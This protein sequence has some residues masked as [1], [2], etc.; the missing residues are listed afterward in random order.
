MP[1]DWTS[2][3]REELAQRRE[4]GVELPFGEEAAGNVRSE[5]DWERFVSALERAPLRDGFPFQEPSGLDEI[6]AFRRSALHR[7]DLSKLWPEYD[8]RVLG[9]WLGRCA[10]CLLG[11]PV[12]GW[13]HERIRAYLDRAGLERLEGYLPPLESA[14]PE[15][16]LSEAAKGWLLGRTRWM[17]R[18]DDIDYTIIGLYILERY[19]TGF[20]SDDVADSWLSLLPYY[21]V[22][23]AERAAYR[24]LVAGLRPPCSAGYRNP[25][26]EWIGAQIRADIWGYVAPGDP[27]F[28]AELAWRDARVSHVKNGI[29]GAMFVAATIAAAFCCDDPLEAVLVGLG[30]IP[31]QSR[32][33]EAIRRCLRLHRE[34]KSWEEAFSEVRRVYGHYSW[35][36][37]IN[38]TCLVVLALLYGEGDFGK[39]VGLAVYGGWDTDCNG[40]TSGSILG[41]MLGSEGI[42][43]SWVDPLGDRV[44]SCVAGF[45]GAL[46]SDL[47]RRTAQAGRIGAR[48]VR[49]A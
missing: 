7:Y 45:D 31:D 48:E 21:K 3:A 39:T 8:D 34:G 43:A 20:S 46:I 41:V 10:G 26:R 27:S 14:P 18:D 36:H 17:P 23:T 2:L 49:P 28:A 42:G 37:A 1:L 38:N 44:Q 24:N 22:Y 25:Y 19:G 5:E 29:Y 13:S 40:A 6:R 9:G 11:K 32:L 4:E 16:E 15:L 33:A 12:E 35:V 47:A 30:E